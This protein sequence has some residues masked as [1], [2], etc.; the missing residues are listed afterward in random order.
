MKLLNKEKIVWF[1][2]GTEAGTTI[3]LSVE[4][5][6][7]GDI[8]LTL[9]LIDTVAVKPPISVNIERIAH[10]DLFDATFNTGEN[11]CPSLVP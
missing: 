5:V 10:S 11:I 8:K 6:C 4:T 1:V 7:L 9:M 2:A 3:V